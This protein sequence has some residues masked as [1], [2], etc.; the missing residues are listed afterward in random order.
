MPLGMLL[1]QGLM[2]STLDVKI[3]AKVPYFFLQFGLLPRLHVAE[4]PLL[5]HL[6][7]VFTLD[8]SADVLVAFSPLIHDIA[9]LACFTVFSYLTSRLVVFMAAL[10]DVVLEARRA[11]R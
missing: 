10:C 9:G 4:M 7:A 5:D 2:L 6:L 11:V 3:A 1:V 8:E